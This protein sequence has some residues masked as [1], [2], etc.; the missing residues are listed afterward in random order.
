MK[1]IAKYSFLL[2]FIVSS[3][4]LI[5]SQEVRPVRDDVGYCWQSDRF[6]LFVRWL[7]E[8]CPDEKFKSENLI[9]GISPHDDYLYAGKVYY[10][11]YKLIN[12]K[13]VVIFGVTHGTVR[14]EINDPKNILILDEF[15][16]WKG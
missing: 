10:P 11:L 14:K 9:A 5:H 8:N 2:T 15:E 4:E 7:D 12:A 13:E 3:F 16:K 1:K 6:D